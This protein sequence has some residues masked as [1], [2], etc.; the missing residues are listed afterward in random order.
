MFWA[1]NLEGKPSKS[2]G[3]E[4]FLV[5]VSRFALWIVQALMSMQVPNVRP[6][7][8]FWME[9]SPAKVAKWNINLS[10]AI[11]WHV[12]SFAKLLQ[13][14]GI[15]PSKSCKTSMWIRISLTAFGA[16]LT[17]TPTQTTIVKTICVCL[18]PRLCPEY[19]SQFYTWSCAANIYLNTKAFLSK[20]AFLKLSCRR[21][22]VAV[23]VRC[24]SL[25]T[26][27]L[28]ARGRESSLVIIV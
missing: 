7:R 24:G 11:G 15:R 17:E 19:S 16:T 9:L 4:D 10:K 6:G 18:R 20:F 5:F 14:P 27:L 22:V 8:R 3:W 13:E 25:H 1:H 2:S 21:Q 28:C 26:L 12:P 23:L